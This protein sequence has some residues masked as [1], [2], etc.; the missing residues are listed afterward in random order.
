MHTRDL[1][2]TL[3][4][5]LRPVRRHAVARR[6]AWSSTLGV[7]VALALLLT[8][9]GMRD[10][11]PAVLDNPVFWLKALF[12]ATVAA[13]ALLLAARLARPGQPTRW[14][15]LLVALP[16][17]AVWVASAWVLETA[18]AALRMPMVLGHTWRVATF[19]I[20]ALSLPTFVATFWAVRGLAP[21]RLRLAGMGAGV[22]AGAQAVLV[23]TLYCTEMAAPFWGTWYVLGMLLPTLA[24]AWLGP[25]L[26][27]W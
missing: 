25:R 18:P 19:N 3:A 4:S 13:A 26:L 7:G 27:R 20:L 11:L 23:Y 1:I 14:A 9:G 2:D 10:D 24:G 21:T 16:L 12:P 22:L 6:L 5:N 15:W 17:L 8:F